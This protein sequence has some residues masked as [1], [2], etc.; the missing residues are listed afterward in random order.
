MLDRGLIQGKTVMDIGCGPGTYVIPFSRTAKKV[1]A[2]DRCLA[3][4]ERLSRE[5]TEASAVN[6]E[7][8][9]ADC[10]ELP[11]GLSCDLAFTSLCPPMNYPEA[12]LEM[13]MHSVTNAYVSSAAKGGSLETE[14]WKELG[15][16]YSY[17]GYNTDFG[18]RY[19]K[20][21][22]RTPWIT[23]FEQKNE[24]EDTY[25]NVVSG[26]IRQFSKFRG[27][28]EDLVSVIRDVVG[29]HEEDGIVVQKR[30][31]RMGLLIWDSL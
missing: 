27:M 19:L 28:T 18:Y 11:P 9:V 22:G 17:E 12:L 23:Y 8:V 31:S 20:A 5:C 16:D 25:E 14:I 7:Q 4:L 15:K 1:I 26:L 29:R 30:N 13:E 2:V 24:T 21:V 6:V 10:R 3:M